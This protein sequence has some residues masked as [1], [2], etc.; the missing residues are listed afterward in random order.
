MPAK[1][2]YNN[3]IQEKSAERALINERKM[4]PALRKWFD[5]LLKQLR[6]DLYT[7][8]IKKDAASA[9]TDWDKARKDGMKLMKPAAM[10]VYTSGGEFANSIF[11]IP[12]GFDALTVDAV[13]QVDSLCAKL[14]REV[15]EETKRGIRTYIKQGIKEGKGMA[16]VARELRPLVGLTANQ[17]KSIIN[18]RKLLAAKHPD[19]S[20]KMLDYKNRQYASKTQTRRLNTIAR[21]ETARAQNAG[22][23]QSMKEMGVERLEFS[24]TMGACPKCVFLNGK[25]FDTDKAAGIIPVHP[26]CRCAMLPVIGEKTYTEPQT[27]TPTG[28]Q[29]KSPIIEHTGKTTEGFKNLVESTVG[30][31]PKKV[32]LALSENKVKINTGSRMTQMRPDLKGVHP[33][34]WPRGS[35]FDSTEAAYSIE[36]KEVFLAETYRPIR[37]KKFVKTPKERVLG[38]TNHEVGHAFS[39]TAKGKFYYAT[40]DFKAAYGKDVKKIRKL[41][42]QSYYSDFNYYMQKGSRGRQETF[43]ECFANLMGRRAGRV[44]MTK[45]FPNVLKY[46]ET[47]L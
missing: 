14:V 25:Y 44:D 10:T 40:D 17:T 41:S 2:I 6:R 47:L 43:A 27:K 5:V 31:F 39:E 24:A 42:S 21:T 16:K 28:L 22:Y 1:T 33:R 20:E 26:N 38:A 46:V 19:M 11:Q 12:G 13:E 15:N 4:L 3:A 9:F 45:H 37:S 29:P 23:S 18:H 7:T 8:Y 30:K 35:S 34:G 36:K 32:K